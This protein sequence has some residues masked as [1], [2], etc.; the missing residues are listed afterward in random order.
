MKRGNFLKSL[1]IAPFAI[2]E[3]IKKKPEEEPKEFH[4]KGFYQDKKEFEKEVRE[5]EN[6][7]SMEY[8]TCAV[9]RNLYPHELNSLKSAARSFHTGCA[10]MTIPW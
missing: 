6:K 7:N 1:F 3:V 4:D 10:W 9:S 8:I 5:R 2:K